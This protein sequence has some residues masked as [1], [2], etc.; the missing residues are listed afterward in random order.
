MNQAFH[1]AMTRSGHRSKNDQLVV[2][3]TVIEADKAKRYS[4]NDLHRAAGG[5]ER[6]SPR[7]FMRSDGAQALVAELEREAP[8][9][10][11]PQ[12]APDEHLGGEETALYVDKETGELRPSMPVVTV[13]GGVANEQGTFVCKELVYA[14]AMWLS[15]KFQLHVIRAYDRL[16]MAAE[17][18]HREK[19]KRLE[20][21]LPSYPGETPRWAFMDRFVEESREEVSDGKTLVRGSIGAWNVTLLDHRGLLFA[22]VHKAA[23]VCG[24][25]V[26]KLLAREHSDDTRQH[27]GWKFLAVNRLPEPAMD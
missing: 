23:A 13:R 10:A 19:V 27:Q 2:D 11:L 1:R 20:R 12:E 7:R 15:P 6:H 24:L 25:S 18:Q 8:S 17:S 9:L 3:G 21:R 26:P 22:E 4:L 16:V 5:E 14:Y